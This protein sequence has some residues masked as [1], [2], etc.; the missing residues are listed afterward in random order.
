MANDNNNI[1]SLVTNSDDD[2]TS[3]FEVPESLRREVTV[4]S[5]ELE[6]DARTFDIDEDAPRA[7]S[8]SS[9]EL[10]AELR[11]QA[12]TIEELKFEI[13]HLQNQLRGLERE[14]DARTDIADNV[15]A[16]IKETRR[17][18]S[19]AE[20]RLHRRNEEFR[21]LSAAQEKTTQRAAELTNDLARAEE[22]AD[23]ARE[24]IAALE[25]QAAA[26]RSAIEELESRLDARDENEAPEG[27]DERSDESL[28]ARQLADA[29][30]ELQELRSYVDGRKPV[31]EEQ[32][33]ELA[34]R[35]GELEAR[36]AEIG[37]LTQLA[38]ERQVELER[39]RDKADA[40]ANRLD[41]QQN[42]LGRLRQEN[43]E[44]KRSLHRDA[45]QEIEKCHARIAEQSGAIASLRQEIDGLQHDTQRLE[46]YA[47]SL[48][49]QLQDQYS[50]TRQTLSLRHRLEG[51]LDSAR[52]RIRTLSDDL[53]AERETGSTLR[54]QVE[55][56]KKEFE[57]EVRQLRFELGSAQETVAEQETINEQLASDLIDNRE[58][59][60]ALESQISQIEKDNEKQLRR[61]QRE[62]KQLRRDADEYERKMQNKDKAIADLMKELADQARQRDRN[63]ESD[64]ILH[65]IDG[66]RMR[67]VEQSPA[68]DRIA[69]LLVGVAEGRELRFPLFNDRLTIGRTAHNDIQ[70]NMQYV[71][72]RHAV[73]VTDGDVTRIIDWGSK[74]GVFVNEKRVTE[75]VLHSGDI[76]TIGTTD[77]RYEEKSKR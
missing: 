17:K 19:R 77:F 31:W 47:D 28:A 21:T 35:A 12:Q 70:L 51:E 45:E 8:T 43:R 37:R 55:V 39:H 68:T 22:E 57:N 59:R 29:R 52:E 5:V 74:N 10:E 71:S 40:R 42:E 56:L 25:K 15:N 13:E 53:G 24:K 26:D 46:K 34:R 9:A 41:R 76:V 44:L 7:D 64:S 69:R 33:R 14:V 20:R 48:R 49:M 2:P 36:D 58:F 65:K 6:A 54:E 11:T 1:N 38:D 63:H 4:E 23:L 50:I 75:K 60:E 72:R 73:V 3:E 27:G 18:L 67:D 32:E 66:F 30:R 62:L 61:L 16:E